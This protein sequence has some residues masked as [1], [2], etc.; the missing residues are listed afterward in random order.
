MNV[1][2]I[3]NLAAEMSAPSEQGA[4]HL[5]RDEQRNLVQTVKAVN[6]SDMLKQDNELTFVQDRTLRRAV[7]QIVNKQT[8]EVVDQIPAEYV[9]RMAEEL[10]RG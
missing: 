1:S 5:L 6:A 9:L 7:A 4:T 10:N 3:R 8:G 2:S